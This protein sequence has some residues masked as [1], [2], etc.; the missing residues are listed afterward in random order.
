MVVS[1]PAPELDAVGGQHRD[2]AGAVAL[3]AGP[4][5]QISGSFQRPPMTSIQVEHVVIR[6]RHMAERPVGLALPDV[7][8]AAVR[9][10]PVH[11]RR[12]SRCRHRRQGHLDLNGRAELLL[13]LATR[14]RRPTRVAG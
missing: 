3:H 2:N 7:P 1:G 12:V 14:Q 9:V 13:R 5:L 11:R 6:Q 10:I 8:Q 4:V